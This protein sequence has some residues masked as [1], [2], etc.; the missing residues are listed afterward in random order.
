[1]ERTSHF[2]PNPFP[3][4]QS[5]GITDYETLKDL[6]F[7]VMLL[8]LGTGAFMITKSMWLAKK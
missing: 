3:T 1:M 5:V 7:V 4:S 2:L 6:S 8:A